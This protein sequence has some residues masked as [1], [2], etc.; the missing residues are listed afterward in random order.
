[1]HAFLPA[2][3]GLPGALWASRLLVSVV[4]YQR[5]RCFSFAERAVLTPFW[6]APSS[7]WPSH[8]SWRHT[9]QT[10]VASSVTERTCCC[11]HAG[12]YWDAFKYKTLFV[13]PP[14]N[15]G[16]CSDS[17]SY[18]RDEGPSPPATCL[19]PTGVN[20]EGLPHTLL[21]HTYTLPTPSAHTRTLACLLACFL[22]RQHHSPPPSHFLAR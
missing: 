16:D 10:P 4:F 18:A 11:R 15:W 6:Q 19:S 17:T 21:T 20:R 5:R 1:M 12:T 14:W 13:R 8:T 2:S 22:P 7:T 9:R 3:A